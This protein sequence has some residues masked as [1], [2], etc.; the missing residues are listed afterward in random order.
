MASDTIAKA[1][2]GIFWKMGV[3]AIKLVPNVYID[4][5]HALDTDRATRTVR[6]F[7]NPPVGE[8]TAE[9]RPPTFFPFSNPADQAGTDSADAANAAPRKCGMI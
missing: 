2:R 4:G 1:Y 3:M 7:P 8:R 5:A 6:N 9:I